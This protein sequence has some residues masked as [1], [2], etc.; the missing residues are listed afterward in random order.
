MMRW[1]QRLPLSLVFTALALVYAA[2]ARPPQRGAG[3]ATKAAPRPAV[4][5]KPANIAR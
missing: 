3:L 2:T 5:V 1:R 4:V